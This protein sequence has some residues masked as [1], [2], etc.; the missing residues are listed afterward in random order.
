MVDRQRAERPTG[1]GRTGN[2]LLD[3]QPGQSFAHLHA[4]RHLVGAPRKLQRDGASAAER[5]VEPARLE[6]IGG[7]GDA[8]GEHPVDRPPR[9]AGQRPPHADGAA[10]GR[11]R[12]LGLQAADRLRRKR[13]QGPL[14]TGHVD[15]QAIP[16]RIIR[17]IR[18]AVFCHNPL[19]GQRH[20]VQQIVGHAAAIRGD[21]QRKPHGTRHHLL[22]GRRIIRHLEITHDEVVNVAA[23]PPVGADA[24]GAA[25][26]GLCPR[27]EAPGEK[28][29][30]RLRIAEN[31]V[32]LVLVFTGVVARAEEVAAEVKIE[33]DHAVEIEYA[34][35]VDHDAGAAG[36]CLTEALHGRLAELAVEADTR[37]EDDVEAVE[38]PLK[39]ILAQKHGG[40]SET[41]AG[42]PDLL[43]LV[44]GAQ[45]LEV[46][47]DH[48]V[49]RVN[50]ADPAVARFG[51]RDQFA[52]GLE[53]L[54]VE[55]R[56]GLAGFQ[57]GRIGSVTEAVGKPP[58]R[59]AIGTLGQESERHPPLVLAVAGHGHVIENP[60]R[61]V[62]PNRPPQFKT[63]QLDLHRRM[64][65]AAAGTVLIMDG[66]AD[67]E[68]AKHV[69][70]ESAVHVDA[71]ANRAEPVRDLEMLLV[72]GADARAR[73]DLARGARHTAV[74]ITP[75]ADLDTAQFQ[76]TV[77]CLRITR[78]ARPAQFTS[79]AVADVGRTLPEPFG[80]H[81]VADAGPQLGM[82]RF[83]AHLA[84]GIH[85]LIDEHP[86]ECRRMPHGGGLPRDPAFGCL[87][88]G[89]DM[90][91]NMEI[92][93]PQQR[94]GQLQPVAHTGVEQTVARR[95]LVDRLGGRQPRITLRDSLAFDMGTF[96]A[97]VK[98]MRELDAG[99]PH[100]GYRPR[101]AVE[102]NRLAAAPIEG[103]AT[104]ILVVLDNRIGG[105]RIGADEIEGHRPGLDTRRQ[106]GERQRV[107]SGREVPRG[108]TR[109]PQWLRRPDAAAVGERHPLGAAAG[110]R[111]H[112]RRAPGWAGRVR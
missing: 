108:F 103:N 95:G 13:H 105:A 37:H 46:A 42:E 44:G 17:P 22:E 63:E 100:S 2:R 36:D 57:H 18:P 21:R 86:V 45:F 25:R 55:V 101:R 90:A 32:D 10:V 74:E 39:G 84:P 53:D 20:S 51:R 23:R 50:N 72:V 106:V 91:R 8:R 1:D 48:L 69:G 98:V 111:Q 34:V 52:E 96:R 41:P 65:P 99:V 88:V 71:R 80:G 102:V 19:Q 110:M 77:D 92:V 93:I 11:E 9:N 82:R 3:R 56:G 87:D 27:R 104:G 26:S 31:T 5:A 15:R 7:E 62:D 83:D 4:P 49:P 30:R 81:A 89:F 67:V 78:G 28:V 47:E 38:R 60:D 94:I 54:A 43:D 29:D 64:D 33:P 14:D 61:V 24:E 112:N 75:T 16:A 66:G 35:A 12:D 70:A 73:Q 58:Q 79:H 109:K 97:C 76:K 40:K 68:V 6:A 107:A 85:L 59:D